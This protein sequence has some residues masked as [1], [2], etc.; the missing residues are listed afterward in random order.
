MQLYLDE[1]L[2]ARGGVGSSV[3]LV[4]D[5]Q[6]GRGVVRLEFDL[7]D[8][9][10][11]VSPLLEARHRFLCLG[12]PRGDPL[13]HFVTVGGRGAGLDF[14]ECLKGLAVAFSAQLF[15]LEIAA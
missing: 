9:L 3:Q 1:R 12:A 8:D 4:G 15:L 5:L 6:Q 10:S 7:G 14:L 11:A 13:E 2:A